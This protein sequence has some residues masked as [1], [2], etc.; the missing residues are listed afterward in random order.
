MP[1]GHCVGKDSI[2]VAELQGVQPNREDVSATNTWE[3]SGIWKSKKEE[4]EKKW[5]VSIGTIEKAAACREL[6]S[7]TGWQEEWFALT[8]GQCTTESITESCGIVVSTGHKGKLS[9]GL[10]LEQEGQKGSLDLSVS[11]RSS[12]TFKAFAEIPQK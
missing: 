3:G 12:L 7:H 4:R 10:N 2:R 11:L 8:G 5:S 1:L 6:Q 9:K